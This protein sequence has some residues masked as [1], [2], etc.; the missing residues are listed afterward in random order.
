MKTY[1]A[2]VFTVGYMLFRFWLILFQKTKEILELL[3]SN[4][5]LTAKQGHTRIWFKIAA[6]FSLIT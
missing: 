2:F 3:V 1:A 5:T 6:L 4:F